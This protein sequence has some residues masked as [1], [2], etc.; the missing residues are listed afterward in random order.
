MSPPD[1]KTVFRGADEGLKR[2]SCLCGDCDCSGGDCLFVFTEIF[3]PGQPGQCG[4]KGREEVSV[5][6]HE[7]SQ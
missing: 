1:R 7:P 6:N 4:K 5:P 3:Y 2:C